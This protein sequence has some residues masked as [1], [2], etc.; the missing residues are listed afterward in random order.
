MSR[1]S[2][3]GRSMPDP[4]NPC[5]ADTFQVSLT[6]AHGYGLTRDGWC[7]TIRFDLWLDQ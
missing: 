2:E 6:S 1:T 3:L 5:S 7:S 4:L